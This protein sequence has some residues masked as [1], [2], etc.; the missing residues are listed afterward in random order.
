MTEA[1]R[2]QLVLDYRNDARRIATSFLR[3]WRCPLEQDEVYSAVD[4]ALCEAAKNFNP[5]LGTKFTT[6][7]YLYLKNKMYRLVKRKIA[8]KSATEKAFDALAAEAKLPAELCVGLESL[9]AENLWTNSHALRPDSLLHRKEMLRLSSSLWADL[10]EFEGRILRQLILEEKDVAAVAA[11]LGCSEPHI[12]R[13]R[14]KAT[15]KLRELALK[16]QNQEEG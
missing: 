6:H 11:E 5:T 2:R 16:Q 13:L 4:L 1:A 14:L 15:R 10:P 9:A 7:A 12:A 3:R 8:A